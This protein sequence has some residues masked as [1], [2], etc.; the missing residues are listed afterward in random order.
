MKSGFIPEASSPLAGQDSPPAPTPSKKLVD[1]YYVAEM[2]G[3][4]PGTVVK[5]ASKNI[6]PCYKFGH[7][8]LRFDVKEI[9][10]WLDKNKVA[11][12]PLR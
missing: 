12:N 1:K 11:A 3:V 9:V 8:L 10:V 6:I 5:L 2:L 4:V 7:R